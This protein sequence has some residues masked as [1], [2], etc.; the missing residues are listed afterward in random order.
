MKFRISF[1]FIL[2]FFF[3]GC[4]MNEIEDYDIVSGIGFD[5]INELFQV[6]YEIYEENN[7]QTTDLTST[8]ITASGKIISEAIENISYKLSKQAYLNHTLTIIL[9]KNI[10]E[11]KLEETLNYLIHDARIR[12]SCYVVVSN[13][14]SAKEILEYSKNSKSVISYNLYRILDTTI[15]NVGIWNQSRFNNVINEIARDNF[16][17]VLPCVNIIDNCL[18]EDAIVINKTNNEIVS[19]NEILVYQLFNNCVD[20]GLVKLEDRHFYLKK[21][22]TNIKIKDNNLFLNMYLKILTYEKKDYDFTKTEDKEKFLKIVNELVTNLTKEVYKKNIDN[23]YD[24]FGIINYIYE[25][26]TAIYNDNINNIYDYIKKLDF[27]INIDFEFL[28]LG[29]T[30]DKL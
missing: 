3:Y 6:T 7:G 4:A 30:E 16:T 8:T 28:T 20:E 19:K 18:I 27:K 21:A 14:Y 26:K 22:K 2:T 17:V 10:I 5:Y 15:K 9:N 25:T 12:S 23:K 13:N 29:L 1:L 11:N 24:P